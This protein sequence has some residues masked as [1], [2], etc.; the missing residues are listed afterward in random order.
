MLKLL[1]TIAF[2][3]VNVFTFDFPNDLENRI[4]PPTS[5]PVSSSCEVNLNF[6]HQNFDRVFK[7]TADNVVKSLN[8]SFN[9]IEYLEEGIFKDLPNIKI[10]DLSSNKIPLTN[11]LSFGTLYNLEVLN[12]SNNEQPKF[13]SFTGNISYSV[14]VNLSKQLNR[15]RDQL[16]LELYT[17][18]ANNAFPNLRHLYLRNVGAKKV[19]L[20]NL[21]ASMPKLQILDLSENE[22][23]FMNATELL[24]LEALKLD[25]NPFFS[26]VLTA[27]PSSCKL[28]NEI[29][30]GPMNLLRELSVS[31]CRISKLEADVTWISSIL[32]KL[33]TLD[34]SR[35]LLKSIYDPT[36]DVWS[37]RLETVRALDLSQNPLAYL[38]GFCTMFPNL[39]TL[40]LNRLSHSHYLDQHHFVTGCS[41]NLKEFS[42]EGNNLRKVPDDFL[43]S[44]P[45]LET[46]DLTD[47]Q[48]EEFLT[49]IPK[50][51]QLKKLY[52][53][54]NLISNI[55]DLKLVLMTSLEILDIRDNRIKSINVGYLKN[56]PGKTL[57]YI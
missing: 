25:G 47:N 1:L 3:A 6:S 16:N 2:F 40:R 43:R 24:N 28:N 13:R 37:N 8:L 27:D 51:L 33:E 46:L 18:S 31:G 50:N 20:W 14:P 36:L 9:R 45:K 17:I 4:G 57:I 49:L 26:L 38:G 42:L 7:F 41:S 32:P 34:L 19:R 10:L 44:L 12:S 21:A 23:S 39:T 56:F 53:R 29:C 15:T 52:L 55:E 11:L 54:K 22:I 35:N 48:L 30:L 5:S